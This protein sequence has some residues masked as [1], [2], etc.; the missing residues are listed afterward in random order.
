MNTAKYVGELIEKLKQQ[1]ISALISMSEACWQVALACIGWSYVY[2]AWEALCTPSERRYRF[3][4]CPDKL[5]IKAKCKAFDN[6][7][8]DGCQWY[9]GGERT[10]CGD[11]R[12]FVKWIIQ[13]ITGFE[14]YGDTVS[15]QWNHKDNW[16]VKGQ[17]GV[18]P[19]PQG[20]L[21]NIFIKNSSG[22][23]THT[24]FYYNGS[25][26]ECA[27][28]VQYFQTMKKNRWTHWAIA[29]CF[30]NGYQMPKEPP[31]EPAKEPDNGGQTVS[32]KK[33]IRK[34]NYGALVKECQTMLNKLGYDLGICGI[35]GDFGQA[36]EKA[37]KAFQKDHGLTQDGVVGQKTWTALEQ[38]VS[39]PAPQV[40]YYTVTIPHLTESEADAVIAKY[41]NAKKVK[42]G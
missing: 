25:T 12:G 36:T 5:S 10:R 20:V 13:M 24:G 26:C 22:K 8:C 17:F 40:T 19:I 30:A 6:G 3:K 32:N 18:D 21:V 34:G 11:C 9:P 31:K 14:L 16:C 39:D 4:L 2:S 15:A 1:V 28:G 42:E 27:S 33:T 7:N 35:D 23:W 37:V 41:P 38:A 29:K